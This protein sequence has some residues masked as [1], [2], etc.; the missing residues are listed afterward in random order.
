MSI[1][2]ERARRP[3]FDDCSSGK[4]GRQRFARP[5]ASLFLRRSLGANLHVVTLVDFERYAVPNGDV[6]LAAMHIVVI[7][8]GLLD[9]ASGLAAGIR[10]VRSCH[11]PGPRGAGPRGAV[12][13]VKA[14]EVE[15]AAEGGP[16]EGQIGDNDGRGRLAD[17]PEC[18]FRAEGVVEAVEL[19]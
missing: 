10:G 15:E 4:A 13:V 8:V 3:A 9:V 1:V 7:G 12:A 18:P 11:G 6:I 17:V 16:G 14:A 5:F 2:K 19:I